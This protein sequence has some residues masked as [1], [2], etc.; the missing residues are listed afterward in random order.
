VT[1]RQPTTLFDAGIV[2]SAYKS[3]FFPMA[4]SRT[5]PISWFSPDPRAIIPIASFNTPRSLRKALK[6]QPCTITTDRAFSQV[7]RACAERG[8]DQET[9]ISEEI[10]RVYSELH[11]LGYAHSIE[12]WVRG[13]LEGG[14]YGVT[15]GAAFF[16]ESMFS[17]T[18]NMS[19]FALVHLVERLKANN[20]LLLDTQ[21]MN[22]HVRQFGAIEITRA[23]YLSLLARAISQPAN[24]LGSSQVVVL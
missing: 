10:I 19:K 15:I 9:W 14:L 1:S 8:N 22:E 16:G 5:G 17:R 11:R 13:R 2:L 21:I 3:G 7:I 20:F 24:F 23:A 6:N 12:T 18:T 4:E